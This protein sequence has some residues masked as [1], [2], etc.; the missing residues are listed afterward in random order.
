MRSAML[1]LIAGLAFPSTSMRADDPPKGWEFA[2]RTQASATADVRARVTGYLTRVAVEEGATVAKGDLLV[3]ID[4]RPYR[5]ALEAAR[6]QVKV[7]EARLETARLTAANAR[8]LVENKVVSPKE[9]AVNVAA[10]AEAEATLLIA[11]LGVE[12]A[13]LTLSWTRITSPLKG[14][15]SR[16]RATEGSLV[17]ADQTPILTVVSTDSLE[18]SF[19]VPETILLQLRR[20]GLDKP[21]KLNVAVGYAGEAGHPHVAKLDRIAPEIDARTGSGQLR[22]TISNPSGILLPGMSARVHLT[23]ASK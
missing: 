4:S 20:D 7:A 12:R 13:E 5:L 9:L 1:V 16:L 6:A 17:T 21:G 23:P 15:V 11:K 22:A 2:G 3:E 18:V 10:V 19:N 14:R 8:K